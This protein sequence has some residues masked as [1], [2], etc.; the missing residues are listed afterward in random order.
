MIDQVRSGR[1]TAFRIAH[2]RRVGVVCL[3]KLFFLEVDPT[4]FGRPL[5]LSD[6]EFNVLT[7]SFAFEIDDQPAAAYAR[8]VAAIRL[9]ID[10]N[11]S[12]SNF[13]FDNGCCIFLPV[14]GAH[15]PMVKQRL[16]AARALQFRYP[17]AKRSC[18]DFVG[19][20]PGFCHSDC[21]ASIFSGA[22]S[23]KPRRDD[24]PVFDLPCAI[25]LCNPS[26]SRDAVNRHRPY[27][28]SD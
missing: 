18:F 23:S 1:S 22:P 5:M 24:N 27:R 3:Q 7:A 25:L 13:G 28:E 21:P 2:R 26:A 8:I 9:R 15:P 19:F 14:K 20:N 12:E 11:P 4:D 17:A 6:P 10:F 16:P